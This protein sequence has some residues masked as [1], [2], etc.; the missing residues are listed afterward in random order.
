MTAHALKGDRERCLAAGMDGYI[1][2]PIHV[3]ELFGAIER[4]FAEPAA[5]ADPAAVEPPAEQVI[6]WQAVLQTLQ[7]KPELLSTVVEA[8]LVEMPGLMET[9]RRAIADADADALRLATHT[10]KGSLRYFGK[11]AAF[12]GVLRLEAMAKEQNLTAAAAT[13]A[14]I[15]PAIQRISHALRDYQLAHPL[16]HDS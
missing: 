2:K 6:D 9:I 4:L 10:L 13:L 7:N 15:E 16:N 14:A 8:E 12:E 11:T 3:P 5:S 1:A